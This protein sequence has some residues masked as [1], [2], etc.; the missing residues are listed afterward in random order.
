MVAL[1]SDVILSRRTDRPRPPPPPIAVQVQ[2][3]G[4]SRRAIALKAFAAVTAAA[5]V[6]PAP[7]RT[8]PHQYQ[9]P[10]MAGTPLVSRAWQILLITAQDAT[11]LKKR[12]FPMS[13]D[14]VA[15][16]ICQALRVSPLNSQLNVTSPP[17]TSRLIADLLSAPLRSI[18][19]GAG[20]VRVW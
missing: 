13:V 3:A 1:R 19:A 9:N 14:D 8:P 5:A 6:R 10:T 11:Y 15:M 12:G 17:L 4:S 2:A 16:M 7:V 18:V 20:A